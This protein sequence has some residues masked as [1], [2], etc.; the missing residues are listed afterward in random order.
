[1]SDV[2]DIAAAVAACLRAGTR[3]DLAWIVAT[4]LVPTPRGDEAVGLTPGGGR[5]GAL[6]GGVLDDRIAA[7]AAADGRVVDAE[8]TELEVTAVGL[9]GSRARFLV[10]P[11]TSLPADLWTRLV[12][13]DPVCLMSHVSDH[14]VTATQWYDGPEADEL[15]A[16]GVSGRLTTHAGIVTVLCPVPRLAILGGGSIVEAVAR[17]ADVLGW[18][19]HASGDV[20]TIAGLAATL[21]PNDMVLVAAHSVEDAGVALAEALDGRA[22]YVGA[23]GSAKMRQARAAWLTDRGVTD[24]GRVQTPAGLD[25]GA[26][27][28]EEV[29]VAIVAEAIG[30]RAGVLGTGV[31]GR[32]EAIP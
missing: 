15:L 23:L 31:A 3:V 27:A 4:D 13:R 29:A 9:R 25:I 21:T 32:S 18:S 28:P 17:I 6:L 1:M 14:R 2:Y 16:R 11:A 26:A 5:I 24:L 22:G 8:L 10:V 7:A 20:A 30:V 12:A 19:V